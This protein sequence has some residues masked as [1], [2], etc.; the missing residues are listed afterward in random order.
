MQKGI[1]SADLRAIDL[2]CVV[3]EIW[4]HI[5]RN[6]IDF[7]GFHA[8]TKRVDECEIGSSQLSHIGDFNH[9]KGVDW[10]RKYVVVGIKKTCF[11][12]YRIANGWGRDYEAHLF[13]RYL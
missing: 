4:Y 7:A 2:A 6:A 11:E 12:W 3:A 5:A 1:Q 8:Q 9:K 13:G 10:E